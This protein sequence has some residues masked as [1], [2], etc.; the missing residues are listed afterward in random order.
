MPCRKC[1]RF[2]PFLTNWGWSTIYFCRSCR[3]YTPVDRREA[4]KVT[5]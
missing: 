5:V 4:G 1:S 3:V 2:I